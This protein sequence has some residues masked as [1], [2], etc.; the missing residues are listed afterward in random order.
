MTK[1]M[2]K[3]QIS[4][5]YNIKANMY[6][7]PNLLLMKENE[8]RIKNKAYGK[9]NICTIKSYMCT[10][11]VSSVTNKLEKQHVLILSWQ[12]EGFHYNDMIKNGLNVFLR[13]I[14]LIFSKSLFDLKTLI[15]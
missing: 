5:K 7:E 13:T 3:S 8:I 1:T 12:G 14:N 4:W 2:K 6:N 15:I 9:Y 11:F 10:K